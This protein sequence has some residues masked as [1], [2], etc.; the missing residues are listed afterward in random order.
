MNL[1]KPF[2]SWIFA[3]DSDDA[4]PSISN[5]LNVYQA[6]VCSRLK[7]DAGSYRNAAAYVP[8]KREKDMLRALC[9]EKYRDLKTLSPECL[10]PPEIPCAGDDFETPSYSQ[11][12]LDTEFEPLLGIIAVIHFTLRRE[13]KTLEMFI[14]IEKSIEQDA[15]KSLLNSAIRRQREMIMLLNTK[16]SALQPNAFPEKKTTQTELSPVS[17]P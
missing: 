13:N 15:I 8:G 5:T 12:I 3:N 10:A 2:S 1:Q 16:L 7:D 14:R 11:Y 9:N 17:V 4:L 6:Y